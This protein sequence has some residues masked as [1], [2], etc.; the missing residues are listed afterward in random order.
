MKTFLTTATDAI[1]LAIVNNFEVDSL[2]KGNFF[3]H[4][5]ALLLWGHIS[6]CEQKRKITKIV[7][8]ILNATAAY[9]TFISLCCLP[10]LTQLISAGRSLHVCITSHQ[11]YL[12]TVT[13][14]ITSPGSALNSL[15]AFFSFFFLFF[16][17][18]WKSKG[19]SYIEST[20]P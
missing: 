5:K 20:P 7:L 14:S 10:K 9:N 12:Q 11:A 13:L 3:E 15:L 6:Q 4:L 19:T 2:W 16:I 1:T 8:D 18:D 17:N